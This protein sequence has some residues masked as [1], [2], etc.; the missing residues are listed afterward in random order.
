MKISVSSYS[1]QQKIKAGEM[2]QLDVPR[3]A[4][5]MGI[6]GI[7]FTE[8]KPNDAPTLAEQLDYAA[9]IRA[10]AEKYGMTIVGYTVGANLYQGSPEEDEKEVE[11]LKG[12]VDVAVAMG[13][14]VMRHDVCK[15]ERQEDG[16]VVSFAKM[17]PTIAA[18]ARKITEY[19]AS[20]GLKTCSENHG[21]VA[22]DS[23]RV[24]A[25]YNAV[26][27]ENYGLL[28][29]FGNFACVDEDSAKAVSRL[30]PYAFHV[31]AKDFRIYP[32]GRVTEEKGFSTR[33]CNK[34]VGCAIGEGD[35]PVAQCVAIMKRV[36]YD[37]FMTIEYE[38]N[39]DCLVGIEKGYKN[40][41]RFIEA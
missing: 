19:A 40:L 31:H 20:K 41:K 28:I 27:H 32:H 14:K 11:R 12:Q 13:A 17:L 16:T 10:E 3:V 34:L 4:S 30:A 8:L 15:K 1:Y 26:N 24:E 2:T 21:Y 25:L 9:K 29:D 39:E 37:S 23:D 18:N 33:G 35:I 36:G 6:E 22:Q 5:E 7:D 38:G